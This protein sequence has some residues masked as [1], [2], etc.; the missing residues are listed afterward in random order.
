M[1]GPRAVLGSADPNPADPEA[2]MGSIRPLPS[3]ASILVAGV[4]AAVAGAAFAATGTAETGAE[5]APARE[6]PAASAND[7]TYRLLR[8]AT[9]AVVTVRTKALGDARS[10]ETLG[11]ERTGSGI[12]IA[13]AGLVLTIGYLILEADLVEVED[14][15]G[16]SLPAS[17]V[18]YDHATGFGLLRVIGPLSSKPVTLGSSGSIELLDRLMIA[19]GG[20][21][22]V[23]L[24]TV[25]SRR[26]FAGYWEY[27]IDGAIFTSPPRTDHSGAALIDRNGELVG[28]GSLLVMDAMS[29]GNGCPATCSSRSTC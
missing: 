4:L 22:G 9:G 3:F 20:A 6:P 2:T 14:A 21:G 17:V 16:R 19:A 28:I 24:A 23:S 26:T 25:V 10:V 13:P 29:P 5:T 8:E 7:D 12:V 11:A 15:G 18:A 27:L 1:R